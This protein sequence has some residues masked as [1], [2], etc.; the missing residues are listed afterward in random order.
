MCHSRLEWLMENRL[1][2]SIASSTLL[3]GV[4][5]QRKTWVPA[6]M[7]SLQHNICKFLEHFLHEQGAPETYISK[8]RYDSLIKQA[9]ICQHHTSIWG[10]YISCLEPTPNL[11]SSEKPLKIKDQ[12]GIAR[13]FGYRFQLPIHLVEVL[14]T[15]EEVSSHI[16]PS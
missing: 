4:L 7:K 13:V 14:E 16:L 6:S 1:G 5:I 11:A 12:V 2:S 10:L 15:S 9:R 3:T 8:T